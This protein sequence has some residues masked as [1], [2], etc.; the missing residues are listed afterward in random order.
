MTIPDFF[1]RRAC[2]IA[3]QMTHIAFFKQ[4]CKLLLPPFGRVGWVLGRAEVDVYS[5]Y[6]STTCATPSLSFDSVTTSAIS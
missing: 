2:N 1:S 4:A 6:F 3:H 5:T